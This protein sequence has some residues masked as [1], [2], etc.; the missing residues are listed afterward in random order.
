MLET[1]ARLLELLSLLQ[2]K[3]DWTSTELAARLDVSTRTVRADVGKLRTLGYPVDARPGVAGG[4]RL[5]AGTANRHLVTNWMATPAMV[6][7][8]SHWVLDGTV[9]RLI[10]WQRE[11]LGVR[12]RIAREVLGA[13]AFRAHP[14]SLH[15]WMEL[16]PGRDEEEF[17]AQARQRGVAIA[18][19][20]AFRLGERDRREAVRIALGSTGTEELRRGL[21]LISD[22]LGSNAEPLLPLV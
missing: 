2:L 7:L 15:V 3:R 1:S 11:A 16:P 4:Y 22:T 20:R 12:H 21:S 10:E 14:Q 6:E 19:G 18:S 8:L 9:D 5:A 17:V 13:G